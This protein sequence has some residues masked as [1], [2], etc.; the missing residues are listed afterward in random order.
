MNGVTRIFDLLQVA[1]HLHKAGE[2]VLFG[3][4]NGEVYSADSQSYHCNSHI[5]A[6]ALL[7]SEIKRTI[8]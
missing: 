5:L 1:G 8:L 7:E 4:I 2:P 6:R 3:K